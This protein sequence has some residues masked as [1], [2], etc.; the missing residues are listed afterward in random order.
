FYQEFQKFQNLFL[1]VQMDNLKKLE[2]EIE[3][4]KIKKF[5]KFISK[6]KMS[7][8]SEIQIKG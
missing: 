5:S 8:E 3:I 2:L 4:Y 7:K 1:K 6:K